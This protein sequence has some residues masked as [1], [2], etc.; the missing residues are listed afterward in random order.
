MRQQFN[1]WK[2]T[3]LGGRGPGSAP[4][5]FFVT[6]ETHNEVKAETSPKQSLAQAI[7]DGV[8]KAAETEER[9]HQRHGQ[10][11]SR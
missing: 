3:D 5:L 8:G 11:R 1:E 6:K 7:Q 4:R 10:Q 2:N 9:S